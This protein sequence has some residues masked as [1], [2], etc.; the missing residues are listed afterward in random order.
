MTKRTLGT[1]GTVCF[2]ACMPLLLVFGQDPATPPAV[3]KKE[4][5]KRAPRP[6]VS[7]PGVKREM[8]ALTPAA[9]FPVPGTPDWQVMTEDAVWGANG[10]K[11]TLHRVD[12][13]THP[14]AGASEGGARP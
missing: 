10:P 4:R 9:V 8:T 11:N 6:G 12:A 3:E 2:G 5:P 7:T 13:Q 1:V 14:A